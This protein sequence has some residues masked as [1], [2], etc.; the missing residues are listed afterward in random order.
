RA[1]RVSG[2][3]HCHGYSGALVPLSSKKL[4]C[5]I[6]NKREHLA[7]LSMTDSSSQ[8]GAQKAHALSY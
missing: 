7:H 1:R 4:S 2:Y 3:L 8:R 5:C 6:G